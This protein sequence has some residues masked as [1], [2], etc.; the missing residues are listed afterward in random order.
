MLSYFTSNV[1]HN[2]KHMFF[3][4]YFVSSNHFQM[5]RTIAAPISAA[6]PTTPNTYSI[7]VLTHC[8]H[9]SVH[10]GYQVVEESGVRMLT[11]ATEIF[12]ERLC[13]SLRQEQ[14]ADLEGNHE[15]RRCDWTDSVEKVGAWKG[16]GVPENYGAFFWESK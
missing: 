7:Y 13:R 1:T 6:S 3:V 14:D 15:P 9:F 8:V 11:E 16:N 10:Q 12:L 2:Q 5:T 4:I